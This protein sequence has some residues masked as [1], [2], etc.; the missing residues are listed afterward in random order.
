MNATVDWSDQ[1]PEREGIKSTVNEVSFS[2]GMAIFSARIALLYCC[3]YG[4]H[5]L[6]FFCAN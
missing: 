4:L 5:I 6:T 2:P 1:V 3:C